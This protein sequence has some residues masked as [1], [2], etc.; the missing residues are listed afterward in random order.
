MVEMIKKDGFLYLHN[1]IFLCGWLKNL[2]INGMRKS[3]K[4]KENYILYPY[5]WLCNHK[6]IFN[7]LKEISALGYKIILKARPDV[8]FYDHF[9]D[10]NI[11]IV[12]EY[13]N[14]HYENSL[15]AIGSTTTILYEYSF[16]DIPVLIFKKD[17]FN[18]FKDIF[19]PEWLEFKGIKNVLNHKREDRKQN[20]IGYT[21]KFL[22]EFN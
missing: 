6:Y 17:G 18:L 11:E 8:A 22:D 13:T 14:H 19:H 21:K 5:E 2:K 4:V 7:Q 1:E 9:K 10:L 20:Y 12:N 16:M 15:C 3:K